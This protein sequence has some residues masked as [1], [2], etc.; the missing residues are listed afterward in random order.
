MHTV[1]LPSSMSDDPP[2]EPCEVPDTF[3]VRGQ[4]DPGD[5]RGRRRNN[6]KKGSG[7]YAEIQDLRAMLNEQQ[8]TLDIIKSALN[9]AALA[10][11]GGVPYDFGSQPLPQPA[12]R[13]RRN[14]GNYPPRYYVSGNAG[15][16]MYSNRGR[17]Q[18]LE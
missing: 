4:A 1:A 17:H 8:A 13:P 12:E 7:V 11:N 10:L 16:G 3:G 6:S 9:S 18:P 15:R 2:A 14:N 5:T